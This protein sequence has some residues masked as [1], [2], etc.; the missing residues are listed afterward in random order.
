MRSKAGSLHSHGKGV[1]SDKE[2]W[3]DGF[4][5]VAGAETKTDVVK[6]C[7]HASSFAGH[8]EVT[9]TLKHVQLSQYRAV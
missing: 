1:S 3:G 4:V 8:E 9:V 2:R 5:L 7:C 6:R